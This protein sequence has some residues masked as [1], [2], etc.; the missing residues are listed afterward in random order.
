MAKR[1]GPKDGRGNYTEADKR[2]GDEHLIDRAKQNAERYLTK[3]N[4][5]D[6]EQAMEDRVDECASEGEF[7]KPSTRDE[8]KTAGVLMLKAGIELEQ[9][10]ETLTGL[11]TATA[12]EFGA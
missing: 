12:D 11:Y 9:V 6:M 7:W 2:R 4:Q 10:I 8:F 3:M 5:K 1:I